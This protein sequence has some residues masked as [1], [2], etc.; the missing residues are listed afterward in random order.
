MGGSG[1]EHEGEFR[2][3]Q[4]GCSPDQNSSKNQMEK[5]ADEIMVGAVVGK[6]RRDLTSLIIYRRK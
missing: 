3:S 4:S 2:A 6:S 5:S 1:G